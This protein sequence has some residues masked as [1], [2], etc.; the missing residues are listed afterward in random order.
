MSTAV[1]CDSLCLQVHDETKT[2][3]SKIAK[4]S[5]GIVHH[6]FLPIIIIRSKGRCHTITE[7]KKVI[8]AIEMLVS[9]TTSSDGQKLITNKKLITNSLINLFEL[10]Q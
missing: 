8:V 10:D 3:E 4:L 6:E 9:C 1:I 2:A 5:T 7:C